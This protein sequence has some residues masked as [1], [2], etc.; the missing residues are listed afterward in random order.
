MLSTNQNNNYTANTYIG[1]TAEWQRINV[2]SLML[3]TWKNCKA[4]LKFFHVSHI[5]E[6]TLI[7][8]HSTVTVCICSVQCTYLLAIKIAVIGWKICRRSKFCRTVVRS[9]DSAAVRN[10]DGLGFKYLPSMA[11]SVLCRCCI[12]LYPWLEKKFWLH[13]QPTSAIVFGLI[14]PGKRFDNISFD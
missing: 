9:Y 14:I 7:R 10:L 13:P 8:C 4:G 6:I 11:S 12:L 5:R 3:R 1:M 2:N